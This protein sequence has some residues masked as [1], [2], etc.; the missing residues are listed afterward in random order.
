MSP[1]SSSNSTDIS[2]GLKGKVCIVTGGAQGIGEACA[3]RFA[4]VETADAAS[5]DTKLDALTGMGI[6][7]H[8][9]DASMLA[10]LRVLFPKTGGILGSSGARGEGRVV[11]WKSRSVGWRWRAGTRDTSGFWAGAS[12]A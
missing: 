6:L 4:R 7:W 8:L 11:E 5:V 10:E 9:P 12:F 2:F 3:R 1:I